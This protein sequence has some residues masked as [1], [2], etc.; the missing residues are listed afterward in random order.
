MTG[1]VQAS[2]YG[3]PVMGFFRNA[4]PEGCT[5]G[6]AYVPCI[7]LHAMWELP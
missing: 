5:S 4:K 1:D 3:A 2:V 7:Y 6:G